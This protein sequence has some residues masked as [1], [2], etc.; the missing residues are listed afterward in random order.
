MSLAQLFWPTGTWVLAPST[1]PETTVLGQIIDADTVT[2]EVSDGS[3]VGQGMPIDTSDLYVAVRRVIVLAI[4][5]ATL[6]VA[7]FVWDVM[8][9]GYDWSSSSTLIAELCIPACGYFGAIRSSRS[10]VFCFCLCNFLFTAT[11]IYYSIAF[12]VLL[13]RVGGECDHSDLAPEQR[14]RCELWMNGSIQKYVL[15]ADKALAVFFGT[16]AFWFGNILHNRFGQDRMIPTGFASG[17]G[18]D[19][20]DDIVSA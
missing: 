13:S 8:T 5:G 17:S 14:E 2:A 15:H 7:E 1:A 10:M 12:S 6:K 16:L 11:T 3:L 20:E 4:I 9:S 19:S 18:Q